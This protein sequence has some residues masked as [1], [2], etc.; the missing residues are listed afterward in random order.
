MTQ[1]PATG[2]RGMQILGF[3]GLTL[4]AHVDNIVTEK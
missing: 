1:K 4:Y 2:V 3:L